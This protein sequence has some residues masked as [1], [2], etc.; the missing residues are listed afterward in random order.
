MR[1]RSDTDIVF[2]CLSQELCTIY[3]FNVF[4]DALFAIFISVDLCVLQET[5]SL[6]RIKAVTFS[7]FF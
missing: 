7:N 6:F 5:I 4:R 2:W 3:L 1:K